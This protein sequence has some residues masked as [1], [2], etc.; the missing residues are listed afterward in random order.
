VLGNGQAVPIVDVPDLITWM[1]QF[2]GKAAPQALSVVAQQKTLLVVDDS[3]N[4]RRMLAL[5]LE[6]VGYRVEQARDGLE[7][8]EKL[9][10]GLCVEGVICDL[11]MPRL[12]GFG[13][14]ARLRTTDKT[15]PVAML[16]SRSGEKHRKIALSLGATA[17]FSKPY[18]ETE[19][20]ESL[21]RMIS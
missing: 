20:L 12:D 14:L 15:L 16:T 18:R 6:K 11:E 4:V 19:F 21:E 17:Y 2:S 8:L 9:S 1:S 7:A 3:I 5:T 10:S 13:F